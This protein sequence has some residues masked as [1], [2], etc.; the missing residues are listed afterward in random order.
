ME[1]KNCQTKIVLDLNKL[2]RVTEALRELGRQVVTTVGSWDMLHIGHM[3]YLIKAKASGDILVVGVD[4]DKAIKICKGPHR[5][6][7]PEGERLEMLSYQACVDFVT[8]L[9]DIDEQGNWQ[10]ELIKRIRPDIFIAEEESYSQ[11]QIDEIKKF[12]GSVVVLP[13]QAKNTSTTKV[14]QDTVKGHL[15]AMVAALDQTGIGRK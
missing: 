9:Q 5:P 15:L 12:S 1:L 8:L 3:R 4:S 7:I 14:I 11:V 2:V 13:R 10:Y 6:I